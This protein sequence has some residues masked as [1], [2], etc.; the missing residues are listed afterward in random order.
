MT[1]TESS[2]DPSDRTALDDDELNL[3]STESDHE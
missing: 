1:T 2:F 3:F